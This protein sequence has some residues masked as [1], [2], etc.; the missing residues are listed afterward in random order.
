MDIQLR[1]SSLHALL[2]RQ[3]KP[4]P[5]PA[6]PA[7]AQTSQEAYSPAKLPVII[8]EDKNAQQTKLVREESEKTENGFRRKKEFET[9]DGR[10]FSRSEEFTLTDRG[11]RRLV[12]QENA[13]GSTTAFE[14]VVDKLG[15]GSFRRTLRF[16]DETGKTETKIEVD[17]NAAEITGSFVKTGPLALYSAI[18]NYDTTRGGHIDVSA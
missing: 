11:S 16:T 15:D 7:R 10:S 13:S 14:E 3:N 8:F 2:A 12:V 1:E 6:I 4:V 9:A 17:L 18:Q 5:A